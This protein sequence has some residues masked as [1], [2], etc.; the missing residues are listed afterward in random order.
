MSF[1]LIDHY[2]IEHITQPQTLLVFS[3]FFKKTKNKNK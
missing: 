3:D 2:T 1:K